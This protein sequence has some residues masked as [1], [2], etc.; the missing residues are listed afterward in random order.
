[1]APGSDCRSLYTILPD[2][3]GREAA[4]SLWNL[5][6]AP[7]VAGLQG[8]DGVVPERCWQAVCGLGTAPRVVSHSSFQK[9][10]HTGPTPRGHLSE[11]YGCL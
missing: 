1:M 4:G 6:W 5:C 2:T 10:L 8:R 7:G 11:L 9:L 3:M